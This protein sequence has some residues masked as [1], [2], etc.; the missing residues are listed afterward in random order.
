MSI[1][2]AEKTFARQVRKKCPLRILFVSSK[3]SFPIGE[4]GGNAQENIFLLTSSLLSL[5]IGELNDEY[6]DFLN[7]VCMR[8][9]LPPL[10]P[11]FI[12]R[13]CGFEIGSRVGRFGQALRARS[14]Q[15]A[16]ASGALRAASGSRARNA[17]PL[18]AWSASS[19]LSQQILQDDI[20]EHGVGQQAVKLGILALVSSPW[21]HRK[22]PCR[23]T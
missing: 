11:S 18:A 23:H 2:Y 1:R 19:V 20:V 17:L 10:G 14:T 22:P 13:V 3:Y 16:Q 9:D 15:T 7:H 5:T 4:T 8:C 21:R 12:T 6:E